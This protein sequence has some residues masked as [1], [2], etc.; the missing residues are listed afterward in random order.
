MSQASVVDAQ[1]HSFVLLFDGREHGLNL[2]RV[3]QI[4]L[5]RHENAAVA[6][7]LTLSSQFLKQTETRCQNIFISFSTC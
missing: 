2:I 4:A 1:I 7:S 5:E 3:T 6:C